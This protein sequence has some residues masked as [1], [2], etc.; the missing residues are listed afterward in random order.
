MNYSSMICPKNLNLKRRE[1]NKEK[2]LSIKVSVILMVLLKAAIVAP[3]MMIMTKLTSSRSEKMTLRLTSKFE[4]GTSR[5]RRGQ[6]ISSESKN[7]K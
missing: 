4:R 5:W 2:N 1:I 7:N 6:W 3:K